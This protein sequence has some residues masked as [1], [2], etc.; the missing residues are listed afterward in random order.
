MLPAIV[1]IA[2]NRKDSLKRILN[3]IS[4]ANYNN[5]SDINLIISIDGGGK[6]EVLELANEFQWLYGGKK[7]ITH[8]FNLGLREHV[9]SCGDLVNEYESIIMLE[10]DCFVSRNFYN[11]AI[12]AIT[13]YKDDDIIGGISL[14]SYQVNDNEGL[15]FYPI[16]DE[17]SS[18]FM[19]IP[20]SWGQAWTKEQWNR[21]KDFYNENPSIARQDLLPESVKS[22]PETSWKKYFYKYLVDKN[23]FIVYPK[24]SL[25]TNFGDVGIH[26]SKNTNYFQV[27]LDEKGLEFVYNF[28]KLEKSLNKYDAYFEILPDYFE[29]KGLGV[30]IDLYGT[31]QLDLFNY[32][33]VFSIKDCKK[34]LKSYGVDLKPFFQNLV[35]QIP[36]DIIHYGLKEDFST[37][38]NTTKRLL[39]NS[40]NTNVFQSG[41]WNGINDGRL[42][43]ISSVKR[44][45][46]YKIG[47]IL[48]YPFFLIKKLFLSL[49][50]L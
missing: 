38:S 8:E 9:I 6:N 28:P 41:Y 29:F 40:V 25:T 16:Q 14:Y 3:S 45:K 31:K 47:Y 26:F 49:R 30:G 34:K 24:I 36:G 10:E 42:D 21:F 11:Y 46:A 7:V 23:M 33:F 32:K 15:P 27:P 1:V 48:L 39:M 44:S 19:Q 18:Y 37:V 2:Y 17:Y 43:G 13:Y 22:W 50:V 20:S 4:N 12:Q 35:H 5:V